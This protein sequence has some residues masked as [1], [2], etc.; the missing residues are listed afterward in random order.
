MA[1]GGVLR[2]MLGRALQN[3]AECF[4][5]LKVREKFLISPNAEVSMGQAAYRS[6]VTLV[7]RP[8]QIP[9]FWPPLLVNTLPGAPVFYQSV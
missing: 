7:K 3:D 9:L 2:F 5:R 1:R 8:Q 4:V 6:L